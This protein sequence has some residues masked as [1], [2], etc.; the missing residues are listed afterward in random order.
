[1]IIE[2]LKFYANTPSEK[3]KRFCWE[4][5]ILDIEEK[6]IEFMLKGWAIRAAWYEKLNKE[7]GEVLENTRINDL[8]SIF[9]KAVERARKA[10]KVQQK[11]PFT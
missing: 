10:Q 6:L 9:N 3:N 1:M 8:Q 11:R 5:S 2:R 4:C 7:T